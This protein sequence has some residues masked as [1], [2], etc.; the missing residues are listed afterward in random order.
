MSDAL[1]A[2]I[3]SA[4][5]GFWPCGFARMRGEPETMFAGIGVW[6]AKKFWR[7]A[8][9]VTADTKPNDVA[10]V[11]AHRKFCYLPRFRRSK[12]P[13]RIKNPEQ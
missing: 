11:I 12:L 8:T 13:H 2:E 5:D 7:R 1:G 6:V 3:E 4:P 10:V 9:L